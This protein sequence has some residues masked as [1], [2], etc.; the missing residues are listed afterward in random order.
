[1]DL[2]KEQILRQKYLELRKPRMSHG[3]M[4]DGLAAFLI[5]ERKQFKIGEP[6]PVMFGIVY[7]GSEMHMTFQLPS[8]PD[9]RGGLSWFSITGPDGK[10]VPFTADFDVLGPGPEAKQAI[11]LTARRF[12]G[13]VKNDVRW[14]YKFDTL[15]S[16]TIKWHYRIPTT[17]DGSWWQGHIVSNEIKIEIIP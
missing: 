17:S 9:S 1:M 6:I 3:P 12:C 5:C 2:S 10:D 8:G 14:G 11:W 4:K 15:G 16:Y 7:G 13:I